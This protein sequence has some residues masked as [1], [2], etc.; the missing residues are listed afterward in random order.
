MNNTTHSIDLHLPFSRL[1]IYQKGTFDM[2][3][4][5]LNNLPFEIKASTINVKHFKRALKTFLYFHS[6]YSIQEYFDLN[7]RK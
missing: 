1:S 4:S 6:F 3:V 7:N 5:I 2:G